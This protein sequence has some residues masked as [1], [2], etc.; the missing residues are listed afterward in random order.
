MNKWRGL[1]LAGAL[2]TAGSVAQAAT[3]FNFACTEGSAGNCGIGVS[4]VSFSVAAVDANTI[5]FLITNS[6][7]S[8]P[9]NQQGVVTEVYV[10]VGTTT[11]LNL[12][13]A[14]LREGE[15]VVFGLDAGG[16]NL[17]GGNAIAFSAD[18]GV[19]A[20]SPSPKNGINGGEFLGLRFDLTGSNDINQVIS[21]IGS[22]SLRLGLHFQSVGNNEG[23]ISLV[24]VSPIPEPHEWAMM[25][26]GLGLVAA[27]T[28]RRIKQA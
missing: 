26:A 13:S 10:D 22:G 28:R 14:S 6:P 16:P 23:S 5:E 24:S 27:I 3:S 19:D 20:A 1:A 2:M 25:M 21:A 12:D 9:L 4:D 18:Y 8:T 15:G 11:F 7:V 17:P